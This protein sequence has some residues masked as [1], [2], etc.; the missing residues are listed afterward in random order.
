MSKVQDK[1]D[2]NDE[3]EDVDIEIRGP[4]LTHAHAEAVTS[5]PVDGPPASPSK[6][7]PTKGKTSF[8]RFSMPRSTAIEVVD[9]T[10]VEPPLSMRSRVTNILRLP[11]SALKETWTRLD[12]PDDIN[13][14]EII[15][16]EQ[17]DV[18]EAHD[19]K[20]HQLV[21]EILF[22][23]AT[24]KGQVAGII[25]LVMITT[26]V[27]LATMDSV[28]HIREEYGEIIYGFEV[29]FTIIF[30]VEY[31]LRIWCLRRPRDYICSA[32]GIVDIS[33][34]VPTFITFFLPPARPLADLAT[35][36]IFRVI[37]VFRVLRLVRFV[38]AAHALQ[39]NIQAN[40][41]RV[42]VFMFFVFSMIVVIG[43][44]M[45]LI[46]GEANGFTNIPVS[47]YWAVVTLTTVGYGDIAPQTVP[48]RLLAAVVMFSGYGVIACPLVLNTQTEEEALRLNCECPRCYRKL[49]QDDANF[50][51]HCGSALRLPQKKTRR[52][53]KKAGQGSEAS[54]AET[55]TM[56]AVDQ[57]PSSI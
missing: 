22:G 4:S 7:S 6:A 14:S 39:E 37:R 15:S 47:L 27:F 46:E 42:A 20:W 9:G 56:V 41:L 34:I 50:C 35:L 16:I 17:E 2:A 30:S 11:N 54:E 52:S 53:R 44:T 55:V 28:R 29:F 49:H 12:L 36:R 32:M 5:A 13:I 45:Y 48:G 19:G 23:G 8:F 31:V 38:D 25:L 1:N 26:S 24:L 3:D 43:C 40:K 21:H 18:G 51:R 33:S 10:E 57:P